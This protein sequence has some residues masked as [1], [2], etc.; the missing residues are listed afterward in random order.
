MSQKRQTPA[1]EEFYL[2]RSLAAGHAAGSQIPEHTH[3]WHQLIYAVAGV[4]TVWTAEGSWITPPHWALWV[5]ASVPHAI[6]FAGPTALRT[7]YFS[8][9]SPAPARQERFTRCVVMTVSPLLRELILRTIELGMLDRRQAQ[10]R[11]LALLIGHSLQTDS[12]PC[13]DLPQPSSPALRRL[14]AAVERAPRSNET[15]SAWAAQFGLGL[16]TL[17][18]RFR[19]ECGVTFDHWRRRARLA[20]ALRALA[21][22]DSVKTVAAACGYR[23]PSAF[24][25]AF[26]ADF[27]TTPG[28]YFAR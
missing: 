8:P 17:E 11:A 24:V 21:A 9:D 27:G 18:R 10:H 5:P 20:H 6:R 13:F 4:M 22:G 19:A 12:R 16:R 3:R 23:S 14:A 15:A 2:V 1:D 26:R 25:A 7:L 28:E